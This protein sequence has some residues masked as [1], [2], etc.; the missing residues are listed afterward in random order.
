MAFDPFPQNKQGA[1]LPGYSAMP[2]AG[3][4]EKPHTSKQVPAVPHCHNTRLPQP[5]STRNV[6]LPT[7]G[8]D[9]L[10]CPLTSRNPAS[11]SAPIGVQVNNIPSTATELLL[12]A[13][14]NSP[15]Q[16]HEQAVKEHSN[17]TRTENLHVRQR[18]LYAAIEDMLK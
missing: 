17:G 7:S 1:K 6:Q 13:S 18:S 5:L 8:K 15:S 10:P 9:G 3:V 4:L 12:A 14:Y 16:A 2:N 11:A